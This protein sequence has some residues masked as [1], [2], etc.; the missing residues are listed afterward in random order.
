MLERL[1]LNNFQKYL[2]YTLDFD[3]HVTVIVG[4]SDSGKTT[5]LRAL[6]WIALNQPVGA[7]FAH[8][9]SSSVSA[10]MVMDGATIGR[11]RSKSENAYT[12]DGEKF[13]A[14]GAGK[15][16]DAISQFLR[17]S[18]VNFQRQL[19]GSFW[20]LDSP[21]QVAQ[22]LNAIIDLSVID[23]A[24]TLAA[25]EV[26]EAKAEAS[27]AAK[28]RDE[29]RAA[30]DRLEWV[31][32]FAASVAAMDERWTA[33]ETISKRAERL[34]TVLADIRQAQALAEKKPPEISVL[35]QRKDTLERITLQRTTLSQRI[36][37][38]K[39][40]LRRREEAAA[41]LQASVAEHEQSTQGRCPLC[42]REGE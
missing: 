19:E 28:R 3:P 6:R 34:R 7:N 36:E 1:T 40:A 35:I 18:G 33:L 11:S 8:R 16:P 29:A 42:G 12:L 37:Y 24:L 2:T 15:V 38:L 21:S 26:R 10:E 23:Q 4:D 5:L 30:R 9:G 22:E 32:A 27:T 13:A 39:T 25:A 31:P 17:V 14:F 20:L 41:R